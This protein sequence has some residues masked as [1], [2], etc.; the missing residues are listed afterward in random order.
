M[1]CE[2][3]AFGADEARAVLAAG[4]AAGLMPRVHAN[5]LG[6]GPGVLLAVEAGAASADHCTYLTGADVDALA[7]GTRSPPCFPAWSSPPGSP[8]RTRAACWTPG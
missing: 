3:G 5:Q 7:A 2:R 8:T 4:K 6:P 1:F